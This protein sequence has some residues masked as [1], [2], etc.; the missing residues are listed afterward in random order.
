MEIPDRVLDRARTRWTLDV[1]TGCHLSTYRPGSHG[2]AQLGW[3]EGD[4]II[5]VLHHRARWIAERGPIPDG[6]TID[7]N[8]DVC[9][10]ILCVNLEHLRLMTRGENAGDGNR[11]RT[12]Y[13]QPKWGKWVPKAAH[14]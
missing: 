5:M 6:L 11:R 9:R 7:H 4:Q 14:A 12:H 13:Y 1:A 2:Y 10:S 3:Q 8:R